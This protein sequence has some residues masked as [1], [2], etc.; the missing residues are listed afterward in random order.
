MSSRPLVEEANTTSSLVLN[1]KDRRI[2]ASILR[3]H[4]SSVAKKV[5]GLL[6]KEPVHFIQVRNQLLSLL[7]AWKQIMLDK[8]RYDKE[9]LRLSE[10]IDDLS[11]HQFLILFHTVWGRAQ[12]GLTD[13]TPSPAR[14]A[15]IKRSIEYDSPPPAKKAKYENIERAGVSEEASRQK[16]QAEQGDDESSTKRVKLSE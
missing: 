4:E 9:S 3:E 1:E 14:S 15:G 12:V 2:V 8:K 5:E 10:N 13:L 11:P 6:Q 16:R 7:V